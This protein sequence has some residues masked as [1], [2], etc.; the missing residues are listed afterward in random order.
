MGGCSL[1]YEKNSSDSTKFPLL[2]T[3]SCAIT[4]LGSNNFVLTLLVLLLP[5]LAWLRR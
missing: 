2:S 5:L 1:D 4:G 3:R